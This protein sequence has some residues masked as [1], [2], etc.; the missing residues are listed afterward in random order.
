VTAPRPA[1]P[2]T[3]RLASANGTMS[4]ERQTAEMAA[5]LTS[6]LALARVNVAPAAETASRAAATRVVDMPT[7]QV[8]SPPVRRTVPGAADPTVVTPKQRSAWRGAGVMA[9]V[10]LVLASAGVLTA[11]LTGTIKLPSDGAAGL[12]PST[13]SNASSPSTLPSTASPT[14]SAKPSTPS[15]PSVRPSST[16]STPVG[17]LPAA[18]SFPY[19]AIE[20]PLTGLKFWHASARGEFNAAC[21]FTSEGL[22]ATL[23]HIGKT[24]TYRCSGPT[25]AFADFRLSVTVTLA[26]SGSC[27]AVWFRLDPNAGGYALRVCRDRIDL[28]THGGSIFTSLKRMPVNLTVGEPIRV[29]IFAIGDTYSVARCDVSSA[30]GCADPVILGQTSDRTF[31]GPNEVTVGIF[32]P[33]TADKATSYGATFANFDLDTATPVIV[34]PS[35]SSTPSASAAP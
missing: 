7:A 13:S 9:L 14:P 5:A 2:R 26:T 16:P 33:F 8:A 15:T 19:T 6:G 12:S 20:D 29:E 4:D 3:D 10:L 1:V 23:S 27:G 31:T 34:T 17:A 25:Q 21:T 11:I 24:N 32:E 22:E 30:S 35:T 28:G 18:A